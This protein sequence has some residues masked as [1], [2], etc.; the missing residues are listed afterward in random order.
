M[1]HIR[2]PRTRMLSSCYFTISQNRQQWPPWMSTS[3][4]SQSDSEAP[5]SITGHVGT[6]EPVQD[7]PSESFTPPSL[8]H[9]L[10]VSDPPP[11]QALPSSAHLFPRQVLSYDLIL[12][13]RQVQISL[14]F[15]AAHQTARPVH[16]LFLRFYTSKQKP[17][18]HQAYSC[19]FS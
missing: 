15:P 10:T 4:S 2:S 14:E 13:C 6:A 8:G 18:P 12:T 16:P 9:L 3:N 17:F 1:D 19:S 5:S 11:P 7:C